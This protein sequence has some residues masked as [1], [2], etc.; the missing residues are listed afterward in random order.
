MT[1]TLCASLSFYT[2]SLKVK[3][4]LEEKGHTVYWPWGMEKMSQN[5]ITNKELPGFKLKNQSKAI[6][7][8]YKKIK[9][10]DAILVINEE[11]NGIK[12][13]IG[14]NTLMEMGFAYVLKKKIY[15]LH[16]IPEG[17]SWKEEIV[18]M[19]PVVVGGNFNSIM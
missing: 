19:N 6:L 10:S 12:N 3:K 2:T 15:L 1:I 14:G 7:V 4:Q 16:P 9:K 8:H 18:A 11:K 5:K 17:V 13:Y